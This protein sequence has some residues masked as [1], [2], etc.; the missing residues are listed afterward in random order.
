[1]YGNENSVVLKLQQIVDVLG[2]VVYDGNA[3]GT[4]TIPVN[5]ASGI[6]VVRLLSDDN[7]VLSTKVHLNN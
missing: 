7:R 2:R 5:G 6:Y 4:V 3:T 1:V